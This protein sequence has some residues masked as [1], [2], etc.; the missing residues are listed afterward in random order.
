MEILKRAKSKVDGEVV[1]FTENPEN[2]KEEA[3]R[4]VRKA[5]Y[6]QHREKIS[7]GWTRKYAENYERIKE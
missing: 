1:S 6:M 4:R 7:S 2:V 5:G 3:D